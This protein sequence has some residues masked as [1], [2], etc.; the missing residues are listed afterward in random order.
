MKTIKWIFIC[1]LALLLCLTGCSAPILPNRILSPSGDSELSGKLTLNGSTSMSRLCDGLGEAF[2][3]QYP[4]V[5]YQKSN[6]GSGAAAL[7]VADGT[8]LIGDLSRE[9]QPQEHPEAFTQVLIAIDGIAVVGSDEN[10]ITGLST[11][12]IADIFTGKITDWSQVGG[13]DGRITVVGREA[14]SGTRSGFEE[15]IGALGECRY[16]VELSESGDILSR[17]A[18]DPAAIGYLS[19]SAAGSG[20]VHSLAVDGVFP[21]QETV[22]DGS[23]PL[24]R[25]FYEIY[26][27]GQDNPLIDA[28]FSFISSKEGEEIIR[29]QNFIPTLSQEDYHE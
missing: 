7:A 12:Q 5:Q 3:Q 19:L 1:G 22:S 14:S 27:V 9:L 26:L 6:T 20:A 10:P 15:A 28:W 25:P 17:V 8:A 2:M 11:S 18:S 29:N 4:Q 23:Y 13:V 24:V 16:Q 21:S